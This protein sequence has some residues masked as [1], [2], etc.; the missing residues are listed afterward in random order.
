VRTENSNHG[1]PSPPRRPWATQATIAAVDGLCVYIDGTLDMLRYSVDGGCDARY[2]TLDSGRDVALDVLAGRTNTTSL[3]R[4]STPSTP[5]F[6]SPS[7]SSPFP[8]SPFPRPPPSSLHSSPPRWPL[9]QAHAY[10]LLRPPNVNT[11]PMPASSGGRPLPQT[12]TMIYFN[13]QGDHLPMTE[14]TPPPDF[15]HLGGPT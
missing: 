15:V 13:D 8:T 12:C 14:L 3:L 9:R 7:S 11:Q 6:L 2:A 4:P 5:P 10:V 1:W